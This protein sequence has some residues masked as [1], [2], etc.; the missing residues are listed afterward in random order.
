M[1]KHKLTKTL[2]NLLCGE[3][4]EKFDQFL[5]LI[6]KVS[7][8]MLSNGMRSIQDQFYFHFTRVKNSENIFARM[9]IALSRNIFMLYNHDFLFGKD[10]SSSIDSIEGNVDIVK[11]I[12]KFIKGLC[13]NHCEILQLYMINQS[14]NSQSH[15]MVILLVNYVKALTEFI[16]KSLKVTKFDTQNEKDTHF[17]KLKLAY[18]HILLAIR[19]LTETIQGPCTKNQTAIGMSGFYTVAMD[20]LQL[21]YCF[22]KDIETPLTNFEVGKL[23]NESIVLL[24]SLFEQRERSDV[25]IV[26]MVDYIQEKTLVDNLLFVYYTFKKENN[27][28]YTDELLLKVNINWLD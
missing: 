21:P 23:K 20:I 11:E 16:K 3:E 25:I 15:N 9:D 28:E 26:R 22:E 7:N 18:K 2:I 24:L 14:N 4:S 19:T 13:E 6:F 12:M 8:K 1:D 10:P 17:K 5:P 27:A